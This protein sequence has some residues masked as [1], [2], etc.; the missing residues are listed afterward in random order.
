LRSLPRLWRLDWLFTT[1]DLAVP[2]YHFRDAKAFSDHLAQE[3]RVIV[4][5]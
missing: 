5:D 4:P 2:S 3:I 1:G